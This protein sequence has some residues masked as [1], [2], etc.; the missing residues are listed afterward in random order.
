MSRSRRPASSDQP[1]TF[2]G[3][4]TVSSRIVDDLSSGLY[5]SPAAC[6]KELIN[7]SYD[8]D[9]GTV[10]IYV[11]P[12]AARIVVEDDGIGMTKD[13]FERHFKRISESHKRDRS[14]T[15]ATGR[16]KIGK[17]GIGF[18]AANELCDVME[19][20]STT[21]GSTELLRVRINFQEMRRDPAERRK[22]SGD[23]RKA[24]YEG[25]VDAAPASDHYTRIFLEN[26]T[27][28]ASEILA[29][30]ARRG[31]GGAR[32]VYGLHE[33][34]VRVSLA[35]DNLDTWDEFDFYS[36]TF[37]QVALNVPV[38]YAPDWAPAD[39]MAALDS[40][41]NKLAKLA[42]SVNYDG[43]E[44]RKPVVFRPS[45]RH[46][47]HV[48]THSGDNVGAHGYFYVQHGMMRP[49]ELNGVLLRIRNA[50]VGGYQSDFLGFPSGTGQLFRR[51]VSAEVWA[52]DRLEEALNIDRRTLRITHP[53]YIELQ[54]VV[55][56]ELNK[57]LSRARSELYQTGS[58]ARRTAEARKERDRLIA[59][60]KARPE[61]TPRVA[62]E[63]S[64]AWQA[65]PD[66][67]TSR[68]DPLLRKFTVS[69]LYEIVLDVAEDFLEPQAY[70]RFLRALTDRLTG[71]AG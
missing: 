28:E 1:N 54:T 55:H 53:A 26:V 68:T 32:T 65:P 42:F 70:R 9:A 37:L 24:D 20:E 44:M 4:I 29:S 52:D 19:I 57:V 7:N 35:D 31:A 47:T 59:V 38:R 71:N 34:S 23:V 14:D 43:T 66:A 22:S 58:H 48:F 27:G 10:R 17:I 13:E 64:A 46:F 36:Q 16:P 50:A 49:T 11:K 21:E 33:K 51:W 60:T 12:D 67:R 6:L 62:D 18:I 3:E 56:A 25:T 69:E 2:A 5:E 40:F 15:T 61:V 63:V 41:E 45:H 8:A 30:A 39:A